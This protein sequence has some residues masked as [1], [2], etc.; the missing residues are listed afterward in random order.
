VALRKQ[1]AGLFLAPEGVAPIYDRMVDNG[2]QPHAI[3]RYLN[4][5]ET[6]SALG[7]VLG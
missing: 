2:D 1:L 7:R 3:D 4:A 6:G 5:R